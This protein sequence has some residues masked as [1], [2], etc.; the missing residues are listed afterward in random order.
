MSVDE[1]CSLVSLVSFE[2]FEFHVYES[3]GG[4]HLQ[5][6]WI[7]PC[8]ASG[9][10][11]RQYSRKWLLSPSMTRSEIVQTCFKLVL[12]AVEHRARETF[13]YRGK[14]IFGPH[15]DVDQLHH[16]CLDRGFDV[17]EKDLPV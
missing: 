7:E 16:L 4:V 15:F 1:M 2:G 6:V 17:R 8:I 14:R 12:T 13:K 5:A 11:E 9:V 3:R 10:R